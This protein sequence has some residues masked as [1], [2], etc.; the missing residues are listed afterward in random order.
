MEIRTKTAIQKIA[1]AGISTIMA[2]ATIGFAGAVTLADY[3]SPF[4][5]DGAWNTL[6]VVGGDAASADVVG[7]IDIGAT[8]AQ[9]AA[10]KP[11]VTEVTG[12]V[13]EEL[14][15]DDDLATVFGATLDEGDISNLIDSTIEFADEDLDVHE[16]ID[17]TGGAGIIISSTADKDLNKDPAIKIG[18]GSIS[19]KYV[20]DDTVDW[21]TGDTEVT[22][23]NPLVIDFLGKTL[24]ITKVDTAT[25]KITAQIGNDYY[26][27]AGDTVTVEGKTL[28]LLNVGEN[29]IVVQV[30]TEQKIISKGTTAKVGGLR[31]Y[32]KDLFTSNTLSEKSA[33][34]VAGLDA[35]KTYG[36][37]DAFYIPCSTPKSEDCDKDNP[38]WVWTIDMNNA[39]TDHIGIVI[40]TT[41][42]DAEDPVLKVGDTLYLPEN[43]IWA[44][45]D[46]LATTNFN[47][48]TIEYKTGVDLDPP[49]SGKTSEAIFIIRGPTDK[50]LQTES[51]KKT[52]TIYLY[53]DGTDYYLLYKDKDGIQKEWDSSGGDT[54][55]TFKFVNGDSEIN[56]KWDVSGSPDDT[57]S[58]DVDG[59]SSLKLKLDIEDDGSALVGL[60]N[61]EDAESADVVYGTTELGERSNDVLFLWGNYITN[62]KAGTE[63]DT[64]TLYVPDKQQKAFVTIGSVGTKVVTTGGT[65]SV[66]GVPIAKL[67]TSISDPKATNLILV[68]GPAVNRL[69]ARALDLTYPTYGTEAGAA[70]GITEGQGTIKL[71][72]N[73][74]G[75]S[76]VALIVAGWEAAETQAASTVLKDYT[77]YKEKLTGKQVIVSGTTAPY[78]VTAPTVSA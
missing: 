75:G 27:N 2:A 30:G 52:N 29:S 34:V 10:V 64:V 31:V 72:E 68:G 25:N 38:D 5:K 40:D 73:A 71:I 16:E 19:Y 59:D 17:L 78:T 74:F 45:F 9:V 63:K 3:P 14:A 55:I 26:L 12:G 41:W 69:T 4:I 13:Q 37:G 70:L 35:F 62:V 36:D 42:D 66:S 76:N 47:K 56:A 21:D 22:S 32:A 1:A 18:T 24:T 39:G 65:P 53:F 28:K 43:Y 8:L 57:L 20:F 67:D 51:G 23:D 60:G 7:A 49:L 48:Y 15:L 44:K 50:S 61:P 11:G 33:I 77:T 54:D 6:L 46:K 58:I